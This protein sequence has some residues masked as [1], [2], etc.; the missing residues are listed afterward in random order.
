M[1][2]EKYYDTL[3]AVVMNIKMKNLY[4]KLNFIMRT[5]DKNIALLIKIKGDYFNDEFAMNY[6]II[7]RIIE[8][9]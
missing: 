4:T 3:T 5:L 7:L 2:F 1:S 9:Q 8:E 6:N